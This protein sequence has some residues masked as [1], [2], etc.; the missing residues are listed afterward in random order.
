MRTASLAKY[1][2]KLEGIF[3]PLSKSED[4]YLRRVL[5]QTDTELRRIASHIGNTAGL[6]MIWNESGQLFIGG[7]VN[8]GDAESH[9]ANFMVEL[10]PCWVHEE[11]TGK[12]EWV[13]ETS[14]YV[15][16]QH[17]IDHESM[18]NVF[19]GQERRQ[20]PESAVD[21]LLN[22]TRHLASLALD[23]PIEYW[24]SKAKS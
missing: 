14:I 9:A 18:D 12:S 7:D 5:D 3:G 16:C 11:P 2:P 17:V 1:R 13:V 8:A 20:T 22:S 6:E 19:G 4:E 15:D 10:W 21:E 24:M 23:N